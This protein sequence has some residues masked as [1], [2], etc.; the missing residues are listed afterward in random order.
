MLETLQ[1]IMQLLVRLET[2]LEILEILLTLREEDQT[3]VRVRMYACLGVLARLTRTT[4]RKG[5]KWEGEAQGGRRS[6]RAR[7]THRRSD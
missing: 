4:K 6:Q 5:K 2:M 7:P 1:E 3:A